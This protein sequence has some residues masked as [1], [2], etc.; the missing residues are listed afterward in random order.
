MNERSSFTLIEILIVIA[1]L[2]GLVSLLVPNFMEI[3]LKA[4]DAKRKSDLSAIQKALELYKQSQSLQIYPTGFPS[5][6][7]P[8]V[9]SNNLVYMQKLPWE[10]L[11]QCG[12]NAAN[13]YYKRGSDTDASDL[14]KYTLY[15]CLESEKDPNG[16]TC[17][18]DFQAVSG[19]ACSSNKCYK[20]I[21]P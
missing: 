11:T 14:A 1:V 20:L 17:P 6:C 21:E 19:F 3:R 18:T 4:R 12:V 13:F 16:V 5:P 15:A 2:A 10:P 9:D 8:L 7:S